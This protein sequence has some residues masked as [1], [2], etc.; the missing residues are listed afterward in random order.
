MY[1]CVAL[2]FAWPLAN[3]TNAQEIV[4]TPPKPSV[5]PFF[6]TSSQG[7]VFFVECR[8]PSG[9]S[10]DRFDYRWIRNYR[11]DGVDRVILGHGFSIGVG[12]GPGPAPIPKDGLWRGTLEMLPPDASTTRAA[13]DA[14]RALGVASSRVITQTLT[15]GRHTIAVE[16]FD[17]WSDDLAFWTASTVMKPLV[18]RFFDGNGRAAVFLVECRNPSGTYVDKFDIRWIRNY[19]ID[20]IERTAHGYAASIAGGP[21]APIAVD[22]LW[23]GMLELAQPNG[24]SRNSTEP[25][26]AVGVTSSRVIAQT[27]EPGRH[28]IAIQCFD[29]WS[30]E[31]AFSWPPS[32][33]TNA[34]IGSL[35]EPLV[36]LTDVAPR[37]PPAAR[38]ARVEGTVIVEATI[39]VDGTVAPFRVIRSIPLLDQAALD[40]VRQWRFAP[41]LFDGTPVSLVVTL[42]VPFMIR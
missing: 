12:P 33:S 31:L 19:R 9:T 14:E 22:G 17:T 6:D 25:E 8:N 16:C 1:L 18:R 26:R 3:T 40:A 41:V 30:D 35:I 32:Q 13:T 21:F 37:Y 34:E 11:I 29:T 27:I 42:T 10:V 39:G 7:Q 5:R 24:V 20:G 15:P 38:E 4:T 36:K 28:T 23:R 2:R